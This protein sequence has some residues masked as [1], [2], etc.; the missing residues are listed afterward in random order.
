MIEGKK[1]SYLID[2]F[3]GTDCE[4]EGEW[5]FSKPILNPSIKTKIEWIIEIIKGQAIAVHFKEDENND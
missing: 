1:M 3:K 4:I 5:W 2:C